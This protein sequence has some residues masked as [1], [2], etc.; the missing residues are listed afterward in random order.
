M[1]ST[2]IKSGINTEMEFINT[3]LIF[4]MKMKKISICICLHVYVCMSMWSLL[5]LDVLPKLVHK[6]ALNW[7]ENNN[8]CLY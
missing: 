6:I 8:K 7:F 3:W 1:R 4:R 5:P 2:H